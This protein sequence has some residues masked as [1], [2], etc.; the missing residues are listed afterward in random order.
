MKTPLID[1]DLVRFGFE[2]LRRA[3]MWAFAWLVVIDELR[4]LNRKQGGSKCK[5]TFA[6]ARFGDRV[7]GA[8]G[9]GFLPCSLMS[10]ICLR[11]KIVSQSP[12]NSVVVQELAYVSKL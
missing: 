11:F 8:G 12:F 5:S 4:C 10:R 1:T 7:T 6:K 9:R 3:R 2:S